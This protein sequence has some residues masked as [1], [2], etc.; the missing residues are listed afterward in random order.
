MKILIKRMNKEKRNENKNKNNQL[1]IN[2][3]VNE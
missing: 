2:N 1:K 3:Q